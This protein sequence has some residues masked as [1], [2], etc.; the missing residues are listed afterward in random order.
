MKSN[1]SN[2]PFIKK[3]E[4]GEYVYIY[5][6]NTNQIIEVDKSV[7]DIIDEYEDDNADY[8]ESKYKKGYHISDLR[9]S[10]EKIRNARIDHGLFSNYRPKRVTLGIR[11]AD[12][13]KKLHENGIIQIILQLTK[14]CNLKCKYCYTSG[15]YSNFGASHST[16][17]KDTCLKAIDF[18][19]ERSSD[20]ENLFISF[21]GGE[22]LLRFDLIKETVE[23]VKKKIAKK[24]YNFNLTTNGTLLNNKIIEFLINNDIRITVSIDGPE[25][26]N[27][28]YRVFR[29]GKGTFNRIMKNLKFLKTYNKDFFS[30]K[31]AI[32]SVLS[33]PFDN[34]NDI[35]D[36]FSF[37]NTMIEI[38]GSI[39]SSLVSTRWTSFIEDFGLE[40]SI[41][42]FSNVE[43]RFVELIKSSILHNSIHNLT[44]ENRR[45]YL[46]LSNLARRPIDRLYEHVHPLGACHIGLR[47]LFVGTTGDFY[48]CERG[49]RDYKIGCIDNGF[50]YERIACYYRKFE[51][52]LEDCRDCWAIHHCERCWAAIG[53]LEE[54]SGKKK[55]Q[56][57]SF[58]KKTIENAFKVY[59]QL[60]RENP[61]SL[62]VFK[63]MIA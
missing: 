30:R 57:C 27:N 1:V 21:Y 45:V 28:R 63:D 41:K 47:R 20:I 14:R 43:E 3:F 8:L 17:D 38:K 32:R 12:E 4:D 18:F 62:K 9:R 46:I 55:E 5:D 7:Y 36:F 53:N 23:F 50:D 34:I 2:Q 31:V 25:K 60:L 61:D 58:R 11:T 59:T 40:E 51:E 44:I 15:K 37:D 49:E 39:R 24:K 13:V 54:F 52:V 48:I 6:V 42:E 29:N 35:L 16:M 19:C 56:F 10:I 33:P 22:P 26:T